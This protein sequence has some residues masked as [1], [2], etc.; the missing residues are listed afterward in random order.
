[1]LNIKKNSSG[2]AI[3]PDTIRFSNEAFSKIDHT[4][5]RWL[6]NAGAFINS[7]GTTI[8]IDPLLIGFDMPSLI[9]M[10]I[11]PDIIA[12]L[13]ALLIT[14]SDNDHFSK[15]TCIAVRNTCSEFHGPHYVAGLMKEIGINGTGHCINETFCIDDVKVTLTPADHAWQNVFLKDRT[16][17][18]QPEDYCGYWLETKDGIIWAIGDSRLMEEQLTMPDPDVILFDF[19]DSQ[20]HIGFNCAVRLANTYPNS[21]LILWHWGCVDAPNMKEFN[22][23]PE[24]LAAAINN[25]ERIVI[26]APGKPFIMK[27]HH[28]RKKIE[29]STPRR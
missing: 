26:L 23:N 9:D 2:Q 6:G 15:Q 16:R 27:N 1:M 11:E 12:S 14:H 25:P 29:K 19:S 4:E 21:K 8:M 17:D 24:E 5:I 28:F 10:P 22:G 13:K 7:R 3:A 18:F 20:W